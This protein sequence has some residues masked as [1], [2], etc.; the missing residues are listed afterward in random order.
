MTELEVT[1]DE[2][3][4]AT[5]GASYKWGFTFLTFGVMLDCTYRGLVKVGRLPDW[6]GLTSSNWDLLGLVFVACLISVAYQA[7]HGVFWQQIKLRRLLP[8]LAIVFAA[9][10]IGSWLVIQW[11]AKAH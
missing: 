6:I 11:M 5:E 1:R 4:L 10:A 7:A 9:Q 8:V 2:R 3:T